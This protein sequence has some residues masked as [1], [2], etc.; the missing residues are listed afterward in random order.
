MHRGK[1]LCL[2]VLVGLGLGLAACGG[3]AGALLGRWELEAFGDGRPLQGVRVTIEFKPDGGVAGDSGCNSY[4][5][6]LSAPGASVSLEAL[7]VTEMACLDSHRMEVEDAYLQALTQVRGYRLEG[8]RLV[9]LDGRGVPLLT[10]RP[11]E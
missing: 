10:F 5:G 3:N 4:Q 8:G 9:L 11:A 2:L 6:S 7:A 1:V